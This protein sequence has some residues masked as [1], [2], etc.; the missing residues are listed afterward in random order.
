VASILDKGAHPERRLSLDLSGMVAD[1]ESGFR[2]QLRFGL[3][4][5]APHGPG[6]NRQRREKS[7]RATGLALARPV[8]FGGWLSI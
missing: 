8:C 3:T 6:P 7:V 5:S 2:G 4:G 1:A